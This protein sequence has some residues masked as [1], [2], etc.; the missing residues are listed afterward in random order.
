LEYPL[1]PASFFFGILNILNWPGLW[2]AD[3]LVGLII[4]IF[5]FREGKE[6]WFESKE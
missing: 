1:L 5:L 4:V 6:I 2:L 3:P